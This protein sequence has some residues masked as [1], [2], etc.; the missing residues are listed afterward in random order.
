MNHSALQ[1]VR[2]VHAW[3]RLGLGSMALQAFRQ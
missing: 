2:G 3:V 1:F